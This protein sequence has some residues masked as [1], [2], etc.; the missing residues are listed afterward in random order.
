M[1]LKIFSA[2]GT[3]SR[4]QDFSELPMFEGYKGLQA[5]KEV[6]VAIMANKVSM[7]DRKP[8]NSREAPCASMKNFTAK[9]W[10]GKMPE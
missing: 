1:K 4:E 6:I 3:Q 5:V 2:D 8:P 7:L 9:V 10:K